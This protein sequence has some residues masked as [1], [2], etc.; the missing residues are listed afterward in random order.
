MSDVRIIKRYGS[1]K[2][3]DAQESRYVSLEELGDWIRGGQ[4]VRVLDNET[5]EDVT[6]LTLT[7]ILSED[8]KRGRA[9]LPSALLHDI[10]RVGNSSDSLF[11]QDRQKFIGEAMEKL[12]PLDAT[13]ITLFYMKQL[14]LE[15]IGETVGIKAAAVKVKLFR[16]RKRLARELENILQHEVH[17]IL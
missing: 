14:N 5:S 15:E 16:A 9:F 4:E 6:V 8:G 2:L 13:L 12:M 7:Q 3:Y 1:R 10:I 11:S 17:E